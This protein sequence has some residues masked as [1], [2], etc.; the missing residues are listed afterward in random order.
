MLT[1]DKN[2]HGELY[3]KQSKLMKK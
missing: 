3:G 1:C 2:S